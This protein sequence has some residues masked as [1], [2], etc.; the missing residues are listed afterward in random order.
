MKKPI[1][2]DERTLKEFKRLAA[3]VGNQGGFRPNVEQVVR[4]QDEK[5]LRVW[6]KNLQAKGERGW[7]V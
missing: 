7:K 5:C 4:S 1:V 2:M 6:E 3:L